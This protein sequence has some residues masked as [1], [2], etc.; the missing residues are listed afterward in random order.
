M[1]RKFYFRIPIVSGGITDALPAVVARL[2]SL[3]IFSRG[4]LVDCLMF[5]A[6]VITMSQGH[7]LIIYG[8]L[9]PH[10]LSSAT[11]LQQPSYSGDVSRA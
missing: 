2:T 6:S 4:L 8:Y 9:V 3:T 7:S 10:V 1:L 5:D 11:P